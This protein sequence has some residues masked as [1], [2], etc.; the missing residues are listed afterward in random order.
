METKL[1]LRRPSLK[2]LRPMPGATP[3][4]SDATSESP[5]M[6]GQY[7]ACQNFAAMI[8]SPKLSVMGMWLDQ[9]CWKKSPSEHGC[10]SKEYM[11]TK[12]ALRRP[13]LKNL[14]PMPG[15]TP[16]LLGSL[17]EEKRI[18]PKSAPLNSPWY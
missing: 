1:A 10:P 13:S 16:S 2:N 12:L 15:V 11:E 5:T 6:R 14:R 7:D 4:A 3:S 17:A 9:S 18:M 8:L